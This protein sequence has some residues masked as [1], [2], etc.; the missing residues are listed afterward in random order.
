LVAAFLITIDGH[1]IVLSRTSILDIFLATFVAGGFY[2]L[3]RERASTRAKLMGRAQR[4]SLRWLTEGHPGKGA[5]FLHLGLVWRRPWLLVMAV[6]VGAACSVKWSGIYVF[7]FFIAYLVIS[8]AILRRQL[9]EKFSVTTGIATQGL[10]T[11]VLSAP[12][13]LG[14]FLAS[15]TGWFVTNRRL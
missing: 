3:L 15:Y 7:A 5:D 14:V 6:L 1:A 2:A 12:L 13:T 11:F 9:G 4:Q 10:V 8:E